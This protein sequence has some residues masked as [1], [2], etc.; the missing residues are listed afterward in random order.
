MIRFIIVVVLTGWFVGTTPNAAAVAPLTQ[1]LELIGGL[2]S[3]HT[4]TLV[5]GKS[6]VLTFPHQFSM[7]SIGQTSVADFI[8]VPRLGNQLLV[9]G[10]TIRRHEHHR[11]AGRGRH[12]SAD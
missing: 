6:A 8:K 1:P 4:L 5:N 3:P 10:K 12:T 11:G 9:T 7:V 2:T